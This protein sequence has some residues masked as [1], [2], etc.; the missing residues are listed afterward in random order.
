MRYTAA[1]LSAV[2]FY[3]FEVVAF[4]AAA[5]QYAANAERDALA[6]SHINGAIEKHRAA[7]FESMLLLNMYRLQDNTLSLRLISPPISVDHGPD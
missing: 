7:R 4:P 3:S 1:V 5:I 6:A 2:A